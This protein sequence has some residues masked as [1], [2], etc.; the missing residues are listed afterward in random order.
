MLDTHHNEVIPVKVHRVGIC[1]LDDVAGFDADKERCHKF[2]LER[3]DEQPL[4]HPIPKNLKPVSR[5]WLVEQ[6]ERR[7]CNGHV[8][9]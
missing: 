9:V 1:K 2:N 7:N 3:L 6:D 5:D 8:A 4:A